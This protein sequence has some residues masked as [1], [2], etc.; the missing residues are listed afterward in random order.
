MKIVKHYN[1]LKIINIIIII[2]GFIGCCNFGVGMNTEETSP[3]PF[4]ALMK[5]HARE[6]S[7]IKSVG[8]NSVA[9]AYYDAMGEY[10]S[11]YAYYT[12][13]EL[14]IKNNTNKSIQ[15]I[16]FII[17]CFIILYGFKGLA[18]SSKKE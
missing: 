9:E 5:N 12:A 2:V 3:L 16:G 1:P 14:D 15:S 10:L 11:D 17:S 13:N 6:M 18:K 8:G 7:K 4:T